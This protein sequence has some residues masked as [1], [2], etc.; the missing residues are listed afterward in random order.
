MVIAAFVRTEPS[1]AVSAVCKHCGLLLERS[2]RAEFGAFCCAGCRAVHEL[3]QSE[4]LAR[5]YDLRGDRDVPATELR[6]DTFV[7]LEPLL[8][9]H[10]AEPNALTRLTLDVQGVHCAACVWLLQELWRR[11]A[12]AVDLRVNPAVGRVELAWRAEELDLRDYLRDVERFGYRFGP[13]RKS[14]LAA[15]RGL[16][17]RL[18]VCSA[19]ALNVMIF[20]LCYYAGLAPHDGD[21]Y[22]AIGR[23]SFVLATIA[24]SA[25]GSL[26]FRSAW[27]SL[28]RRVAHLDLP[29]ALGIALGYG[30]STWAWLT[31]GPEAAY[32]DTITIFVALMVLG[33]W[34][35]ERVLQRNRHALLASDGVDDLFTRRRRGNELETVPAAAIETGDELWIPPGDLVPVASTL[36]GAPALLSLDWIDGESRPRRFEPGATVPAGAFHAGD[37]A[38]RISAREGF[39]ASR[40]H[41]LLG[42]ARAADSRSTRAGREDRGSSRVAAIYVTC[43]IVLASAA[44]A[45]W[46]HAGVQQATEIALSVL[47][48][49]CPC[50]LG[51]A[52]PLAH[53][54][55]HVGLRRRGIFLRD[56][57]FLQRALRVRHVLFDKTGTLTRG[58]LELAAFGRAQLDALDSETR[59]VVAHATAQSLHPVSRC[60]ATYLAGS[61]RTRIVDGLVVREHAGRGLELRRGERTWRLGSARF[62]LGERAGQRTGTLLAADGELLAT[63]AVE[64]ALKPDARAE[65]S[66]LQAEGYSLH[67]LSGDRRAHVARVAAQLGIPADHAHGELEP[68]AK[69]AYVRALDHGDTCMIG[70][71]INDGLAFDAAAC[72][73]TP[74]ID[75]P[76]LPARADFFY[77]GDGIAAVRTTLH[78]A[79]R[80]ALVLRTNLALAVAY[81]A[82]VVTACLLGH[83]GPLA[84]AV[85]MPA[86]SVSLLALTSWRL[87]RRS[88][89]WTS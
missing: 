9:T 53:E 14:D 30:G 31:R 85:L 37:T 29:I 56:S 80:L 35:Q 74:A 63:L 49:T 65:V 28:R 69:A 73:A 38:M 16:V 62:V 51:L 88:T 34:L 2:A 66:A 48:V 61:G 46:F 43:V 6:R 7:W 47:V 36:L 72:A 3:I 10:I 68:E 23:W 26:F 86:S 59:A 44:F 21:L 55:V 64:E 50:A 76:N 20:S 4:G 84:A 1:A 52:T 58:R 87:S 8:A 22:T 32:F 77:L 60:I 40:L 75:R 70:D 54:L 39:T 89:S 41:E 82:I 83:V 18:G 11:H 27:Q 42:G 5:Y 67:L 12:G 45:L 33:R 78:A 79:R 57:G 13:P 25:G 71:G 81:N 19:A 15:S 17:V 24:V